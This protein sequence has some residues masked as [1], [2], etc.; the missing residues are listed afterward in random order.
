VELE[1]DAARI[2]SEPSQVEFVTPDGQDIQTTVELASFE[3]PDSFS[4]SGRFD[5][6][7]PLADWLRVCPDHPRPKRRT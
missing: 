2:A 7:A 3:K 6:D 4:P 5:H 1:Y